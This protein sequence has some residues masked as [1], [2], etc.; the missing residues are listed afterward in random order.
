VT[1]RFSAKCVV[2]ARLV[3]PRPVQTVV[4]LVDAGGKTCRFALGLIAADAHPFEIDIP[5]AVSAQWPTDVPR[6]RHVN[7]AREFGRFDRARV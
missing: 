2:D 6:C 4:D 7:P 1:S 5:W 3:T